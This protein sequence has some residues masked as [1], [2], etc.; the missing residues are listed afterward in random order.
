MLRVLVA[1]IFTAGLWLTLAAPAAACSC[2]ALSLPELLDQADLVIAGDVTGVEQP[3]NGP[4]R[5]TVSPNQ[6]F[7]G[8]A[9][10]PIVVQSSATATAGDVPVFTTCDVFTPHGDYLG[11]TYLLFLTWQHGNV[12][13]TSVCSGSTPY[14]QQRGEAIEALIAGQPY[15]ERGYPQRTAAGGVEYVAQWSDGT[16]TAVPWE[17]P[18][19]GLVAAY[20]QLAEN[21]CIEYVARW[22]DGSYTWVPFECPRWEPYFKPNG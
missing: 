12:Y 6:T 13:T 5:V 21:G 18:V 9:G 17:S 1:A 19:P 4:L 16:F 22:S 20:P 3:P 14:S 7:K 10:G 2:A 8:L 11:E 15:W